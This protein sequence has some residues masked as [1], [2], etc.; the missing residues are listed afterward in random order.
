MILGEICH[1]GNKTSFNTDDAPFRPLWFE[2]IINCGWEMLA[3]P[4]EDAVRLVQVV[5]VVEEID[6]VFKCL[7]TFS[8]QN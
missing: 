7:L 2:V 6:Q 1:D 3:I 5:V 8:R 4:D